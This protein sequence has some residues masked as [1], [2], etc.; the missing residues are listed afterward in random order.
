MVGYITVAHGIAQRLSEKWR[1]RACTSV[2]ITFCTSLFCVGVVLAGACQ[3]H[4]V[5]GFLLRD[6]TTTAA[7]R[8]AAA[9]AGVRAQ[10][11]SAC[12]C[13]S[14]VGCALTPT[15]RAA[16]TATLDESRSESQSAHG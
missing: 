11:A 10:P 9:A 6:T 12:P 13:C 4:G 1:H 8:V 15:M 2:V 3:R 16:R 7:R 5:G 14:S